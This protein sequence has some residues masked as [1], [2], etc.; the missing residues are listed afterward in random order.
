MMSTPLN[1]L[2]I[3]DPTVIHGFPPSVIFFSY[4]CFAFIV[5]QTI[6][7]LQSEWKKNQSFTVSDVL[8]AIGTIFSASLILIQFVLALGI[9]VLISVQDDNSLLSRFLSIKIVKK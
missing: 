3:F 7:F 5:Y 8:Y 4:A 2:F 1:S 9:F 6:R